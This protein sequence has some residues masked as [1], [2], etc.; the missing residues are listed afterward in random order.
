M[1]PRERRSVSK[2]VCYD[3]G[4]EDNE[5]VLCVIQ[6]SSYRE[7]RVEVYWALTSNV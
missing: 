4:G 5:I 3:N 7:I 6:N 1:I 2:L